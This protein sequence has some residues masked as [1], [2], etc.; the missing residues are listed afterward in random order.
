MINWLL[1]L[2]IN[3]F[4]DDV[5]TRQGTFHSIDIIFKRE[6]SI[7]ADDKFESG[8]LSEIDTRIVNLINSHV[9]IIDKVYVVLDQEKFKKFKLEKTMPKLLSRI[10]Q[11]IYANV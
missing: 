3:T 4:T 1:I 7:I 8:D 9:P 10:H 2:K 6:D 11:V 5:V